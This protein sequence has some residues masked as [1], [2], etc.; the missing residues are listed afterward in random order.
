[1]SSVFTCCIISD[2]GNHLSRVKGYLT[3]SRIPETEDGNATTCIIS[4]TFSIDQYISVVQ[5]LSH[6]HDHMHGI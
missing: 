4:I 1:M 3:K 5:V 2:M 6:F